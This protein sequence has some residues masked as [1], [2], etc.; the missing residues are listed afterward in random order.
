MLWLKNS[1]A[2]SAL[3][4][5]LLLGLSAQSNAMDNL[6]AIDTVRMNFNAASMASDALAVADLLDKDAVWVPAGQVAI[7]GREAIKAF[8]V[9]R[10]T[11]KRTVITLHPGAIQLMGDW[12]VL[13][14][15]FSRL[16][17]DRLN[18]EEQTYSG[19]YLWVLRKQPDGNWKVAYDIWNEVA[20]E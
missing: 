5:F 13:H 18:R 6:E 7:L 10:F 16:D 1:L 14:S 15:T 12:A 19:N 17:A 3:A 8:Y 4:I 11:D 20:D 9:N 2:T